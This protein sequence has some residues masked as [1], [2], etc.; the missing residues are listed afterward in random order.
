MTLQ[1]QIIQLPF[2]GLQT[3]VDP[4]VAPLGTYSTIDNMLMHR[5]PELRKRD[6]LSLIGT[7]TVPS[8]ISTAYSYLNETGV[9]TNSALYSYSPAIDEFTSKGASISPIVTSKSIISNTYTQINCDSSVT[10]NSVIGC[11][12]EDSRGGVR[13]SIKDL[14]SDTFLVSDSLLDS[15]GVKP[16]SV[17]TGNFVGF[18]WYDNS[19]HLIKIVTYNT[20]TLTLNPIH[21][22]SSNPNAT[23]VYDSIAILDGFFIVTA[24]ANSSPHVFKGWYWNPTKDAL[25]TGADGFSPPVDLL[26]ANTGSAPTCVSVSADTS[27]T[28]LSI[29]FA[30]SSKTVYTQTFFTYLA[31]KSTQTEV[32]TATTDSIFSLATCV[33]DSF[34]TYVYYSTYS[35]LHN[36]FLA[37]LATNNATPTVITNAAFLL[38]MGVHSRARFYSG[39]A[40]V[41]LGYTS[42][43]SLQNTYFLVRNDGTTVARLFAT[44]GGGMQ[45]KANCLTNFS[46][47]PDKTNTFIMATMKTTKIISSA[48]DFFTTTSIFTEQVFLT[49][50]SI[51]NKVLGSCLNISGGFL[52]QYDGSPNIFEQG[53]HLYPETP[54]LVSSNGAGSL[55]N[56]G[57]YSY[58]VVWEWTDNQGQLVRSAPSLPANITLGGSDDTVVITVRSLPITSKAD[59]FSITR[60]APVMA[61]YRTQNLGTVYYRVNQLQSEYVYNSTSAQTISYTDLKADTDIASNSTIYTTGGIFDNICLPASNLMTISKNRVIV[62]GIDTQP[63]TVFYSKEKENGVAVEFSNELSFIVDGFGGNITALA[64]VDDIIYIFKETAIYYIAGVLPDKLGNGSAPYPLLVASDCGCNYPQSIVL[65]KDGI[66]F[67]SEKGIYLADRQTNVTYIGQEVDNYIVQSGPVQITSAVNLPNQNLVYFTADDSR[68]YVY[69]TFFKQWYTYTLPFSPVSSALLEGVWYPCSSTGMYKSVVGQ[70]FDGSNLPISS[71]IETNW[72]NL[73]KLEGFGRVFAILLAGDNAELKHRLRV[74]LYYD[75]ESFPRQSVSITP[76]SL[77]T[78]TYGSDATYGSGSPYGGTFDGTY[79]FMIRPKIQKCSA[80]R[81]EI[82]DDFPTGDLSSSFNFS[83]LSLVVGMKESYSK[84]LPYTRRLT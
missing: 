46:I 20:S 49:P 6:G 14:T 17:S 1:K 39:F 23:I 38:Q 71:M 82:F 15:N 41:T 13:Y 62:A 40:Y 70:A 16:T 57:V 36:T 72:I 64:A 55:T 42:G 26:C 83:G 5:F 22:L 60:S 29:T 51:D 18:I 63:N 59:I 8:N 35:S 19:N 65:M 74:N 58:V 10:S 2:S 27:N 4:K 53:Y 25:G 34:N 7:S 73:N 21:T 77:S 52:K 12:W 75:F 61:V 67:Q 30:T 3:K 11:I 78:T 24:E 44:L 84:M 33:D 32:T 79:Q 9:I 76:S 68:T 28:Y 45:T 54:T 56:S 50:V 47:R 48:A 37:T 69:D 81:I 43:N 31:A 80:I 66:M